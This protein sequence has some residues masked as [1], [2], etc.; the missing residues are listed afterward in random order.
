MRLQE[1][2]TYDDLAKPIENDVPSPLT[3]TKVERYLHGPMPQSHVEEV[4]DWSSF[5]SRQSR[6]CD[7]W[8]HKKAVT[9]S[10]LTP[11]MAV[12]ALGE[13]TPGG[14]LMKGFQED[15]LA[16]RLRFL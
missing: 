15:S 6:E 7:T 2:I 10:L 4:T 8:T 16:R 1:K 5:V 11:A 3:L 12:S 14:A 9:P 13:L